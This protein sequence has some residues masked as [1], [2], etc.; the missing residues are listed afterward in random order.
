MTKVAE[1]A[2]ANNM[3]VNTELIIGLPGETWESWTTGL[4][5][6]LSQDIIVEAYPVSI[7]MNSEMN[8]PAYKEKHGITQA[9][10]KSYFSNIIDEYQETL[11]GTRDLPEEQM[12]KLWL[13]TWFTS[14]MDSNGF[15][16]VITRYLNKQHGTP[17]EKF[18]EYLL[19]WGLTNE[20][21]SF[22]PWLKKWQGYGD[23]LEFNM[24]LAGLTYAPVLE[25]LGITNRT[26]TYQDLLT[27]AQHFAPDDPLLQ[28]VMIMQ[29]R[30]Q[31]IF[32]HAPTTKITLA[33]NVFEYSLGKEELHIQPTHYTLH[34]AYPP[35]GTDPTWVVWYNSTRKNKKWQATVEYS[36]EKTNLFLQKG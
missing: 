32:A 4:C 25:D 1:T 31:T 28:D 18:Y 19:D 10:L 36:T 8:D 3:S 11:T 12:K 24:F 5:D 9:T 26:Q 23:K 34:R 27:V 20:S 15:T 2:F 35:K 6:L 30:Q 16:Q 7:L 22:Y 21:C 29:E 33:A 13:W 14:M 17:F